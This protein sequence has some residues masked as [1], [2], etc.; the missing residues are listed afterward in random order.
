MKTALVT[1]P[2]TSYII[3]LTEAKT[4]MRVVSTADNDYIKSLI[5]VATKRIEDMTGRKF[6]S[7]TWYS[8]HDDWPNDNY[9]ELPYAPL[10]SIPSSGV[11]YKCTTGNSTTMSSTAWNY[12]TQQEPPIVYLEYGDTWPSTGLYEFNPVRIQ[13]VYG[14]SSGST[15]VPV[16]IK[17]ACKIMVSHWY[18]NRE[19]G[20]MGRIYTDV[21]MSVD[22]LLAPFKLRW[23]S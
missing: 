19:P 9:I 23:F 20:I 1:A 12:T 3:S 7:Q 11:L 5:K 17:Q 22:A 21:P 2:G 6:I 18:E 4:H 8:Y 14:Y 16:E 15:S 10:R 13:G